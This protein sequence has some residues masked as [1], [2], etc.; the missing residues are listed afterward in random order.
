MDC[1]TSLLL[2]M[3]LAFAANGCLLTTTTTTSTNGMVAVDA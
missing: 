3:C 2:A 1:R